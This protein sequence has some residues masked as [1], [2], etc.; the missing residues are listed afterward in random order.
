MQRPPCPV[1]VTDA[2]I[3][4]KR[5]KQPA[6]RIWLARDCGVDS[7]FITSWS[8]DTQAG[9]DEDLFTHPDHR[10]RG[11]AR[12]LLLHAIADVRQRPEHTD[13]ATARPVVIGARVDDSPSISMPA[14]GSTP[15]SSEPSGRLRHDDRT[16][17]I[18]TTV[19][20]TRIPRAQD[21]LAAT[22]SSDL[23]NPEP[24]AI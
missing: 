5:T 20:R 10:G 3:A 12:A 2:V 13:G 23:R 9:M 18:T 8:G 14:S 7:A 4:S 21:P 17:G 19:G 1:H 16:D 11:M 15:Y 6:L 24:R 22:W